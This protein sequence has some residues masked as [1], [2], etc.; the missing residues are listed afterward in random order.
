MSD[1]MKALT[2]NR[3]RETWA[4]STGLVKE[5]VPRP[6]LDEP[7]GRDRSNV[8]IQVMYAGFCGSDRGIWWRKS[9]GDM[10]LGS[11]EEEGKDTRNWSSSWPGCCFR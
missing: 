7:N 8:I 6:A 4:S 2:F 1:V 9:F 5:S 10:I 11:L 3:E